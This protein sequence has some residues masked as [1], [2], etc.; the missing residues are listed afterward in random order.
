MRDLPSGTVTFLFTDVEGSTRLLQELGHAYADAL[1]EHRAVLRT[2]F[3]GQGGIEVDTQGD[4]F[5]YAFARASDAIT[6]A[7][8]GQA[9]LASGPIR[10]RIG[11]HTG[12]PQL[13]AEGYVGLDVHAGAR[14][15]ACGHGGQVVLSRRT[16]ELADESFSFTDLGEHRLKD[17]TAPVWLFQVGAAPFP[18]LKSLNVTNLPEPVSSFVGRRRELAEAA[19]LLEGTRL[20]TI[21]G[22]GGCGKTRFSIELAR[23]A[24]PG[25]PDGAFW[26]PLATLRDPHLVLHT[27]AQ[28]IG[29]RQDLARHVGDKR[30][31]IL[32]DNF[33]QIVEAA[34]DLSVVMTACP[35]LTMIVTS[36][37]ILRIEGEREY[38]LPS[39]G[40]DEGST[41]FCDRAQEAPSESIIELC[42]H[43]DGL[44]L[45]IELA[46]ARA[47]LL[48]PPQ[49]LQRLSQRLDLWKG[50][51]DADPRHATLRATIEWSYDLLPP[52]EQMVFNRLSVFAGGCT[53]E[54]AESV[55]AA[56][57]DALQALLE[58]SLLRRTDDRFWM[59]E[60]IRE[61]A[62]EQLGESGDAEATAMRHVRFFLGV[63][64]SANLRADS[65]GE[66]R[67]E[68]A[69]RE[70]ANLR[71]A[72]G[73]TLNQ[74]ETELGLRLAVALE[75]HWAATSPAEGMRW[76]GAFEARAPHVPP[77]LGAAVLR[78]HGA[79]AA[80]VGDDKL[81][82]R[83]FE[84]SLAVYRR[85]G[86]DAGASISLVHL[87][88]SAWYRNDRDRAFALGREALEA[89]RKAGFQQSE[90]QALGLLGEL[91]FERGDP[92]LGIDL[93]K[94]SAS[95]AA[96]H[97]FYWWEARMLMRL[98]KRAR[99]VERGDDALRWALESLRL[100]SL[101]SDHRRIVQA[102]DVLAAVAADHGQFE[103]AGCLRGAVEAEMERDPL[104]AWS[105]SP[106]PEATLTNA[107]F[108]RSRRDGSRLDVSRAVEYA[109]GS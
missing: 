22:P 44:P 39:L 92:D 48:S 20:L 103:R 14:I 72:L 68:T 105:M 63:A 46:A 89:S 86:D 51:R 108:R 84:E 107:D 65:P 2:V 102:L 96:E 100:A 7:E 74:G 33:E 90:A 19:V 24:L 18:P 13:T 62:A 35:N 47:K 55:A 60:T 11:L 78:A 99:E 31:L 95:N 66:S 98:A 50:R 40:D 81:G 21:S 45:A 43:L 37:E 57:P 8:A 104:S 36:R 56:D 30:M 25:F 16:K 76:F 38:A 26:V 83:L 70:Q 6:A 41:L 64:E 79:T 12:E 93:L 27:A 94:A 69:V 109:L 88:H 3:S 54:A 28:V 77:G 73:Q 10:V 53:L 4:A 42:R 97:G 106:L 32:L 75:L 15:A 85:I 23:A 17:L 9:A 101:M 5:F 91:E 67:H 49:L 1:A 87:A 34:P 80:T 59:L 61:Y 52:E 82:E 71:A 29:T 58:K